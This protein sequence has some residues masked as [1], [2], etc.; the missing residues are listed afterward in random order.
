MTLPDPQLSVSLRLAFK[1]PAPVLPSLYAEQTITLPASNNAIPGPLKLAKHQIEMAD[2]LVEDGIEVVAMMCAAQ[3]GKTTVLESMLASI[4][5]NMPGPTLLVQPTGD[6]AN[7]FVSQR[8]N[9]MIDNA[10]KLRALVGKGG[11]TRRGH[12]GGTNT[13]AMKSFPGGFIKMA[14]SYRA[15]DLS[16]SSCRFILMDEVDRFATTAGQDGNPIDLGIK[17]GAMF[18]GKGRRVVLASTPTGRFA[19]RIN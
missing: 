8:L 15:E 5:G 3:T 13:S 17:R 14:S 6:K 1:P 4:I 10:P 2:S 12:S 18:E 9:P 16:A 19:S 11:L 7:E